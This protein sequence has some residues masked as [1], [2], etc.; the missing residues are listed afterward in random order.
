MTLVNIGIPK[1]LHGKIKIAA[2]LMGYDSI[3]SATTEAAQQW[4]DRAPAN[5]QQQANDLCKKNNKRRSSNNITK[6]Q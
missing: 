1:D 3:Q 2:T 5:I 4:F 6:S